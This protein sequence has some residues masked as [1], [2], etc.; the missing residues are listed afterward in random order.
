MYRSVLV[1][2]SAPL[3]ADVAYGATAKPVSGLSA[4]LLSVVLAIAWF[5]LRLLAER[6]QLRK[7]PKQSGQ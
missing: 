3:L 5:G 7:F 2:L 6:L 4:G 1:V